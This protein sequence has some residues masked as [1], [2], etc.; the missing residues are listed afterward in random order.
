MTRLCRIW[1]CLLVATA[2]SSASAQEGLQRIRHNNPGLVVDLGVGL[3]AWPMP[4]DY[5]NDGDPDLLVACPDKP[6]N[7]VYLFENPGGAKVPVFKPGKRLS[8]ATANMQISYV[9]GQPRVLDQNT[10]FVD[11]LKVGTAR[12][13]KFNVP[14]PIDPRWRKVRENQWRMVDFDGDGDQDLIVGQA[15]WDD[16]GWDDAFD[17]QGRWTRGPLHGFVYLL[18]NSGSDEEPKY[19]KAVALEAAGAP[20]D[21]Y[22]RPTPNL[23]DFDEDGDLDLLCGEFLDGFTYFENTGSR[24]A[25]QFAAGRRPKTPAGEPLRMELEMIVPVAFDWDDDGDEDLICGDEDGRVAFLENQGLGADRTPTFT[26]PVYFRQEADEIKCGALATP[27]PADWDG[28][29]DEDIVC[30]D[31]AGFVS[32]IENLGGSPIKWA[33]PQRL[34]AE[35]ALLRIQAGENGSIQ[36]PAEAKWGYTSPCVGDWDHDG[37][38]DLILNSIW[39]RIVW[40]ENLGTKTAPML[41]APRSVDVAWAGDPPKPAWNWW[42]PEGS[43]LAVEW[44]TTPLIVDF[45]RDGLSDLVALDHEGYL[46]FYR[47]ERTSD[48]NLRLTPGVRCFYCEGAC[49]FDGNHNTMGQTKDSLLRLNAKTAGASGRRKIWMTDWDG[50]GD[51][52]LLVNGA[53]ANWL[54]QVRNENGQVWFR[55]RGKMAE[56]VLAGHSTSPTAVDWD[57]NG[58][59]DLLIGA[60]DGFLYYQPNERA[61]AKVAAKDESPTSAGSAI[62]SSEFIYETASFPE[63]HAGTIVETPAGLVTAWFGGKEE[64]ANDVGIWLSRQLNGKWTDPV[65]VANGIQHST[66]RYPCWNPVLQWFPSG[67]LTLFYKCGPSP[68]EWWGMR[69]DS[70]DNGQSWSSPVR[71]P[72]TIDGPVKNKAV[73]LKDGLLVCGSSTEYDGWRVHI[74]LSK[75]EG[76]TWDRVGPIHEKTTFNA[77][78]PTILQH[79][80]GRLQILC[81]TKEEVVSTSVSSDQGKTWSPMKATSLPNPNSGID[82]V[83]LTDGRFLLI[84]N[85]T[86]RNSGQP[87]GRGLLNVA[88]SSDGESWQAGPVLENERGE[89]SY[90]AVIQTKDGLVHILYTWKRQRLRHVVL[91]PVQLKLHPI[92]DGVWPGLPE[93]GAKAEK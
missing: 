43:E 78:Q 59:P 92:V 79:K 50:D 31:S 35:G 19:E 90:P 40:C 27:V 53:N 45:D 28:D 14:L 84:Y 93:A 54:E 52:D 42:N 74:E 58:V 30:G 67:R 33:G 12:P 16:Y 10:E 76:R 89:F 75:D 29:G 23:A 37:D 20:I 4:V 61:L 26:P 5:D 48:G 13:N 32:F 38:L 80:D 36:G 18:T 15:P 39:G 55:D 2:A 65:E 44:R 81:R 21:V 64:G 8:N 11:F 34:L 47:R 60:E 22:G 69:T 88:V 1:I 83:T 77:I 24:Q 7:G 85:H 82:A 57:R 66:L 71:L 62:V 46:A 86:R 87:R 91:D 68:S 56:R 41:S 6:A 25:P 49:E 63:C 51:L 70:T 17:S 9:D 73:L 3:W 72:Q